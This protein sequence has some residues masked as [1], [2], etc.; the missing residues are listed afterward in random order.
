MR[1]VPSGAA[2]LFNGRRVRARAMARIVHYRTSPPRSQDHFYNFDARL[3]TPNM[4]DRTSPPLSQNYFYNFYAKP[5]TPNMN[6]LT[7]N[8]FFSRMDFSEME[9]NHSFIQWVFPSSTISKVQPEAAPFICSPAEYHKIA[10][11]PQVMWRVTLAICKVL[12]FWGITYYLDTGVLV[13][14]RPHSSLFIAKLID[15]NHNQLRFTRLLHFLRRIH[16]DAFAY[17]LILL[18]HEPWV[19]RRE[20]NTDTWHIWHRAAGW[21]L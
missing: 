6:G 12:R 5:D 2:R 10:R 1:V 3:D 9:T 8:Y 15:T 21:R 14:H 7:F 17:S 11:D 16:R 20:I 4:H 13:V 18:F 19:P